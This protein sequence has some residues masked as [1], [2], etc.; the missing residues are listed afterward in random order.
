M[1]LRMDAGEI[2]EIRLSDP[3]LRLRDDAIPIA[4]SPAA[5]ART[6]ASYHHASSRSWGKGC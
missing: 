4:R 1:D 3:V 2:I 5:R 6:E